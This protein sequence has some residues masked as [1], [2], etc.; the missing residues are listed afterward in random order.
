MSLHELNDGFEQYLNQKFS[1]EERQ[2]FINWLSQEE[3][4]EKVKQY[5]YDQLKNY[6]TTDIHDVD[7]DS[8]FSDITATIDTNKPENIIQLSKPKPVLSILLKVAA[9]AV[10]LILSAFLIQKMFQPGQQPNIDLVFYEVKAPLGA[11]SEVTLP[12]GSL[13]WLNAGSKI[14]YNAGF[15]ITNRNLQLD[16]EAYFTVAKNKEIPFIVKTSDIDIKAVGTSFNVK[17]YSDEG[18]IETTLV[19]GKIAII[20]NGITKKST[21]EFYLEPNQKATF[22]KEKTTFEV[23]DVRKFIEEL[24]PQI[25]V[26]TGKVYIIPKVDPDPNIAWKDN[27]L[28]FRGEEMESLVV[29]LERKYNV[30]INITC[31]YV[32]KFRFS[33]TLDDE[34]LQQVLDV[35]KLSA[36]IDYSV[37][38]KSVTIKENTESRKRFKRFLKNEDK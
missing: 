19:E 24:P 29:K 23:T 32:K 12:D 37:E 9:I 10:I 3:N 22:V 2:R 30:K 4:E 1:P 28:I 17:A 26:E 34:T 13:V 31:D 38:G 7:F 18:T 11:K 27:R 21:G 14:K 25:K 16:G 5:L 15:N 36:P 8:I 33:G 6:S 35:I 20:R